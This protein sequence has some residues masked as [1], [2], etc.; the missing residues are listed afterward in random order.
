MANKLDRRT[1]LVISPTYIQRSVNIDSSTFSL[2][3]IKRCR[4]DQVGYSKGINITILIKLNKF[5][6]KYDKLV[7]NKKTSIDY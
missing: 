6:S 2:I 7:N 5:F 3:E 4:N 1:F